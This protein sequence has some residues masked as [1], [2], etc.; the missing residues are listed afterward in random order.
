MYG[1]PGK[2]AV[3]INDHPWDIKTDPKLRVFLED[4]PLLQVT[5]G[6]RLPPTPH[7]DFSQI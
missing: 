7:R 2:V 6:T 5:D 1:W 4:F 3:I